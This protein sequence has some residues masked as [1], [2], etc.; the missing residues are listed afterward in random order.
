MAKLQPQYNDQQLPRF[1]RT[2]L[3]WN[4]AIDTPSQMDLLSALLQPVK[5]EELIFLTAFRTLKIKCFQ[6]IKRKK[7]HLKQKLLTCS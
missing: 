3:V 2:C 1:A 5:E 6:Q 4:D 7:N